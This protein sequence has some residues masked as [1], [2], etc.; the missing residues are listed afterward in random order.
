MDIASLDSHD[1]AL[2]DGRIRR[3]TPLSP[4][5]FRVRLLSGPAAREPGLVRYSI[6]TRE[7][8]QVAVTAKEAP[9][10]VIVSTNEAAV[11]VSLDDGRILVRDAGGQ[12]RIRECG[13]SVDAPPDGFR[14]EFALEEGIRV[15]GMG[16]V[17]RERLQLRG[18][19]YEIWVR[20]VASYV[21]VPMLLTTGGWGVFVNTT[22][23]HRI[24][25]GAGDPDR[26]VV[27]GKRGEL[28][29]IVFLGEDLPELLE[30]YTDLTGKPHLL[31]LW[32]YGLTFV[33][34][35]QAN[36]R[37]ML[38]DCLNFR[39]AGIPCDLVGLEPGWME[40]NYDYSTDKQWHP[41]R[42]YL[43]HWAPRGKSAVTFLS[44]AER[45]GFKMS[46]W[47]CCN[48]DLSHE[49]ERQAEGRERA[50]EPPASEAQR[51][52]DDFEQ[53]QNFGHDP[54]RIDTVTKP[55]EA[56]F[57]HLKLFV[58]EGAR[59]FKLD[60]ALQVNEH[61]DRKWANGMDDEEM[62]NLYPVILNKQMSLGFREHTGKRSMIYSSGGY[63][64]I[65]RFSATWAGDTGGGPKPLVSILNHGLSGHSNASC[66]MDVFTPEG[67]HFGFLLAWSQVCSWAYWRHPWLL[68][69]ELEGVFTFYARLRYRLLPYIY[70]MAHVAARTGLPIM[71]AMPLAFPDDPASDELQ[72]QY[73]FGQWFLTSA[74]TD[75][76][77]LPAGEWTDYWSGE[78]HTGPT[79]LEVSF[80]AGRGGPL[81][82]R[83]GAIIP[84]WPEMQHVGQRPVDEI[85]LD[86]Y[87]HGDSSFTLYEDDGESY[88]YLEG[89]VA[90]TLIECV[91]G[92]TTTLSI[93]PREGE[94]AG[95]EQHR[96]YRI[97][98]HLDEPTSVR[99]NGT[100]VPRS[101]GGWTWDSGVVSLGA[102]E[103]PGQTDPIELEIA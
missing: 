85:T 48:Y 35:Q 45:L 2:S 62:H 72:S 8:P 47:L 32:G 98:V 78:H 53:D 100:D 12:T 71:R 6:L 5:I 96:S 89:E 76:I 64:G 27:E 81:F 91:A 18:H 77:H 34:N 13:P 74:F 9:G 103:A 90:T 70:S 69:E 11:E 44:A 3:I 93:H 43:P 46:L 88:A 75:T 67:I 29:Y 68:G 4:T 58:D 23:R 54:V 37:E 73:M 49:E 38:D 84:E 52:P 42:F 40:K 24:D 19:A 20:N 55:H 21:P 99:L 102:S 65:Q 82:V 41:E 39:R 56:W 26:L 95:M 28:D 50:G 17:T 94:H 1:I 16:D 57:E 83:G 25:V 61:P 63:A 7:W 66:D 80:P 97:R 86:V 92:A 33:C 87:P 59:A 14:G 30:R 15:Y 101:E 60:G 51:H 10:K 36:A 22:W 31:P 79:D